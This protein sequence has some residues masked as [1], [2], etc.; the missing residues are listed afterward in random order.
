[1]S[2]MGG[3]WRSWFDI[4]MRVR[5][6][7]D[8]HLSLAHWREYRFRNHDGKGGMLTVNLGEADG[9]KY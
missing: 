3:C 5:T 7:N 4:A 1:M 6:T 8:E 2:A 9:T